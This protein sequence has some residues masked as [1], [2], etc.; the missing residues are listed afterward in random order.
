MLPDQEMEKSRKEGR[1][2]LLAYCG[3]YCGD[4]LGYTGVIADAAKDFVA[5]VEKHNFDQTARC[6]FPEK[7]KDYNRLCEML[8]FMTNLKCPGRCR[9]EDTEASCVVRK[10]CREKGFHACYECDEL[11]IC[12]KL[13][14][15]FEGLHYD[16]SIKNLRAIK[17]SGLEAWLREGKRHVHW[18]K[19]DNCP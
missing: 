17:E 9:D 14:S 2:D 5:V 3:I 4:C 6:V 7:L 15:L 12:D 11:E 10:C 13:K 19:A 18:E 16:S 8:G 1:K